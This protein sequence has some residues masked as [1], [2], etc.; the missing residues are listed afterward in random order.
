MSV[1]MT[2]IS[3][4]LAKN[5]EGFAIHQAKGVFGMREKRRRLEGERETVG[6]G[7]NLKRASEREEAFSKNGVS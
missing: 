1:T 3:V 6:H 5:E 7:E 2:A 4:A